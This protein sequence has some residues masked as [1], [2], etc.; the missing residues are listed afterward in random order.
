MEQDIQ[1]DDFSSKNKNI[2]GSSETKLG[3][4]GSNVSA[5]D[6]QYMMGV[7]G[8]ENIGQNREGYDQPSNLPGGVGKDD[9]HKYKT[10]T[11]TL[12]RTS[13]FKKALL[14]T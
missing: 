10:N 3:Q 8:G 2:L 14:E 1:K 12:E 9:T 7:S 11:T 5:N 13:K 6:P 4:S